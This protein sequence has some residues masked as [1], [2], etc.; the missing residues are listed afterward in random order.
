MSDD[1]SVESG[2]C[3]HKRNNDQAQEDLTNAQLE[4]DQAEETLSF[5]RVE[6]DNALALVQ[7]GEREFTR[8]ADE[9]DAARDVID[10]VRDIVSHPYPDTPEAR[11]M[12]RR[13]LAALVKEPLHGPV[14]PRGV[15]C[16][17]PQPEPLHGP[18]AAEAGICPKCGGRQRP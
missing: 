5:V 17:L 9:R 6:R 18:D 11:T 2:E 1:P 10:R 16:D 13:V 15:E 8:V 3:V 12:A 14:G 7:E 4:R